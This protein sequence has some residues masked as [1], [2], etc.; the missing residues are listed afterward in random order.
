MDNPASSCP[1]SKEG[2]LLLP[3]VLVLDPDPEFREEAARMLAR[4]AWSVETAASLAEGERLLAQRNFTVLVLGG[5][6][7]GNGE[8]PFLRRLRGNGG[9]VDMPA[10]VLGESQ[11][12]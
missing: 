6:F 9:R 10:V 2:G 5:P 7:A 3:E 11:D 4:A 8:L 1:P 12:V